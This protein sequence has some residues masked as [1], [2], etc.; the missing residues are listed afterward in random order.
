MLPDSAHV[1]IR[2]VAGLFGCSVPTVWRRVR[3]GRLPPPRKFGS[4]TRF[5]VG[6]IRAAL[7]QAAA[8]A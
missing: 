8:T 5:N 7:V 6:L 2:T 1:Q 4:T 3:E